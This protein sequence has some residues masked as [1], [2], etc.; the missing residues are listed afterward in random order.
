MSD[1]VGSALVCSAD[2]RIREAVARAGYKVT[3]ATTGAEA[4]PRVRHDHWSVIAL[5]ESTGRET[6]AYLH[7]LPGVRR[8]ELFVVS[9]G[10][11]FETGD[12]FQAW[13]RSVDLVVHPDDAFE[14]LRRQIADGMR[15]KD[16]FYRKFRTLQR[17]AGALLGAHA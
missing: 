17:D 9:F 10:D 12:R 4:L 1:I 16:E 15:E 8:R 5:D 2:E 14:H 6:L 11:R 13:S 7:G 3:A